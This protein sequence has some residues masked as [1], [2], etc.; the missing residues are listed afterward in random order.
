MGQRIGPQLMQ[1]FNAIDT[2]QLN[3]HQDQRWPSVV[4]KAD[5]VFTGLGLDGLYP[6]T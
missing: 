1:G 5:A 3:V 2:R 6:L 4:G